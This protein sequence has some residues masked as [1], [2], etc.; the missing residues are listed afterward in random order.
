MNI[1]RMSDVEQRP[2]K[3]LWERLAIS[4]GGLTLIGGEPGAGKTQLM[5]YLAACASQG[6]AMHGDKHQADPFGVLY[7]NT[8]ESASV[9]RDALARNGADLEQVFYAAQ[10][11]LSVCKEALPDIDHLRVIV[12]DPLLLHDVDRGDRKAFVST[13]ERLQ[14]FA[15][16]QSIAMLASVHLSKSNN[17][18]MHDF[19]LPPAVVASAATVLTV[20]RNDNGASSES[21]VRVRRARDT[22]AKLPALRFEIRNGCVVF[23]G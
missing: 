16:E 21:V 11:S 15:R 14:L 20:G 7:F 4:R 13:V 18:S 10:Q 6:V 9:L 23:K 12:F 19:Q 5:L 17:P 3:W 22:D 2:V 8:E 1:E